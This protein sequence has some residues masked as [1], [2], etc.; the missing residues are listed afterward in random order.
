[1]QRAVYDILTPVGTLRLTE[2]DGLLS[3]VGF[4]QGACLYTEKTP[5]LQETARMLH[6]YFA[7]ERREFDLPLAQEQGTAFQNA[8]W[9]ALRKIPYGET[10]SY[11]DIAREIG[12]PKAFRAVGMACHVNP[13]AIIVPCHRVIGTNGKL[14]GYAEGLQVKKALLELEREGLRK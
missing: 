8:V 5:L 9:R 1:M 10:V 7:G 14:T 11:G 4:A 12:H 13:I 6:A 3:G 2:T